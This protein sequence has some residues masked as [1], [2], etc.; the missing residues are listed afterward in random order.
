MDAGSGCKLISFK[1][2]QKALGATLEALAVLGVGTQ[3]GTRVDVLPLL[4][5]V[6]ALRRGGPHPLRKKRKFAMADRM[7]LP[8]IFDRCAR[9]LAGNPQPRSVCTHS[10]CGATTVSAGMTEIR[11]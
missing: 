3:P 4:S 6:P 10:V 5:S 8:E 1:S 2:S 9:A 7:S 11:V